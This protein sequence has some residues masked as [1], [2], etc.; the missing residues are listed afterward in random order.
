MVSFHIAAPLL[1]GLGAEIP[2]HTACPLTDVHV[3]F[4]YSQQ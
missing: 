2:A 1:C 4:F 3:V